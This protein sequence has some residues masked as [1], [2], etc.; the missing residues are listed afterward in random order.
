MSRQDGCLPGALGNVEQRLRADSSKPGM[1]PARQRLRADQGAVF[2]GE[3]RLEQDLHLALLDRRA[4]LLDSLAL[5]A[6]ILRG[7]A[8]EEGVG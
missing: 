7:P 1:I 3:L 2:A 6:A 8:V 4:E 5:G